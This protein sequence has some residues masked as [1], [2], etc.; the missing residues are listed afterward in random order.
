MDHDVN[1]NDRL[2][3]KNKRVHK[4][5]W[6]KV[7]AQQTKDGKGRS[8]FAMEDIEKDDMS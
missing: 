1:C 4:C 5:T 6:K 8:L 7:E 2:D 3:Y